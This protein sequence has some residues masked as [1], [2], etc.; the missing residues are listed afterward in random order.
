MVRLC[1]FLAVPPSCSSIPGCRTGPFSL[2]TPCTCRGHARS[3]EPARRER[4]SGRERALCHSCQA[5]L[6]RVH[7]SGL[8]NINLDMREE[9]R[10]GSE[11]QEERDQPPVGLER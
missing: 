9:G 8:Q 4:S 6:A 10:Q 1:H 11:S 2:I 7:T 3:A 5:V